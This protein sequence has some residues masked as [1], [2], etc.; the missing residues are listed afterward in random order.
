MQ[1]NSMAQSPLVPHPAW[2]LFEYVRI[3]HADVCMF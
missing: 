3:C 1:I 2:K